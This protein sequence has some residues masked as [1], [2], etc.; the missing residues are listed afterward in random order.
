MTTLY[1]ANIKTTP[2]YLVKQLI[3]NDTLKLVY[4]GYLVGLIF[5]KVNIL[6]SFLLPL[7]NTLTRTLLISLGGGGRRAG[8]L[9]GVGL[10]VEVSGVTITRPGKTL[11]PPSVVPDLLFTVTEWDP[12]I[13]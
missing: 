11:D 7:V 8:V 13:K 2:R 5:L 10:G 12:D 6:E 9:T 4:S 3:S 1:I